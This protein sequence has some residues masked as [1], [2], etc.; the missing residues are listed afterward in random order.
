[1]T[2]AVAAGQASAEIYRAIGHIEFELGRF[3][4]SAKSY[5]ALLR[6]KPQ[7]AAGWLNLAMCLERV[8]RQ[9]AEERTRMSGRARAAAEAE[10]GL[11]Q[12]AARYAELYA[13]ILHSG[14]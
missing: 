1:M 8:L 6:L 5:R 11:P 14:S 12:M 4:A 9:P 3:E 10:Y 13:R 7:F 2:R